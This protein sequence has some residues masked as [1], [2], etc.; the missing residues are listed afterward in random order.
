MFLQSPCSRLPD[1][2][3]LEKSFP[4][5]NIDFRLSQHQ[6]LLCQSQVCLLSNETSA[7]PNGVTTLL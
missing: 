1:R 2:R 6:D 7:R 4:G 5:H 3:V